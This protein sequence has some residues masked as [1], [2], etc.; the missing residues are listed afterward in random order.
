MIGIVQS[1]AHLVGHDLA[2]TL[3]VASEAHSILLDRDITH[4]CDEVTE[5]RVLL[6]EMFY[7]HLWGYSGLRRFDLFYVED[8]TLEVLTLGMVDIDGVV[9]RLGDLV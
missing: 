3:H 2:G 1:L 9:H 7:L 6:D 8:K 4:L 5:E